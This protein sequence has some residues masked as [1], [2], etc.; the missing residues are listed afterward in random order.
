MDMGK[1]I[2]KN[3]IYRRRRGGDS[4]LLAIHCRKCK[5]FICFYQKDGHG[6]LFRLYLDR[7]FEPTVSVLNKELICPNNHILAISMIY[8]IK[9]PSEGFLFSH[10]LY[11]KFS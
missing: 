6:G 9:S 3:D 5:S 2:F 11:Q 7:I 1:I 8:Q 10:L 4:K